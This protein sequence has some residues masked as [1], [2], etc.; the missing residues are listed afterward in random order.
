MKELYEKMKEIVT[1][2]NEGKRQAENQAKLLEIQN[3]LNSNN[4]KK[5]NN[6]LNLNSHVK[7]L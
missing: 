1:R 6:A 4:F 5:K 7:T 3:S 2:I